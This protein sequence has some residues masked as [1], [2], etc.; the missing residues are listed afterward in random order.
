MSTINVF[1]PKDKTVTLLV[2]YKTVYTIARG[3]TSIVLYSL[4]T[5]VLS[6]II[7]KQ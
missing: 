5:R 4:Y 7:V 2:V 1:Q 6:T 3:L